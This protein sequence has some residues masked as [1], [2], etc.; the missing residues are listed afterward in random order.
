MV[1]EGSDSTQP[2]LVRWAVTF[3]KFWWDFL[4]GDT[5][6]LFIGTVAV[7]GVVALIC[8]QPGLQTVAAIVMPVLVAGVLI[9]S[10][11]RAARLAGRS[12]SQ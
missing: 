5:P 11:R 12:G 9:A 7:I 1:E 6:E 8:L 3:G 2:M 4:I 10:V